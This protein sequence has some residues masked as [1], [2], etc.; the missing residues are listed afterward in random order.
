MKILPCQEVKISL[1][2]EARRESRLDDSGVSQRSV[3]EIRR[4]IQYPNQDPMA[5]FMRLIAV[6]VYSLSRAAPHHCNL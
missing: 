1:F 6:K 2:P 3:A 4:I 5:I